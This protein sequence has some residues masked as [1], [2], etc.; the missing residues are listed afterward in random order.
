MLP[1]EQQGQL[2]N[3][4]IVASWNRNGSKV[5][6]LVFYNTKLSVL[7][8]CEKNAQGRFEQVDLSDPDPEELYHRQTKKKIPHPGEGICE[9]AVGPWLDENTVRLVDGVASQN[10][11]GDSYTHIY[12]TFK[13]TVKAGAATIS[14]VKLVGPLSDDKSGDFQKEMGNPVFPSEGL[15]NG[16]R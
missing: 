16:S 12:V 9:N 2:S 4:A 13:A 6:L 1:K 7:L 8:I 14:E 10:K 5:A 15:M 3:V 11:D